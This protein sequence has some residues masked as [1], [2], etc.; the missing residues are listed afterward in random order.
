[1][2][3]G[4]QWVCVMLNQRF[5]TVDYGLMTVNYGDF[6]VGQEQTTVSKWHATENCGIIM[7]SHRHVTVERDNVGKKRI[8]HQSSVT[9]DIF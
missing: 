7:V 9:M 6:M 3:D 8:N 5:V 4:G 2:C 1:M